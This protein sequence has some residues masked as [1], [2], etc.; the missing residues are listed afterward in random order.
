MRYVA[1][2][3]TLTP[4]SPASE[5]CSATE[6]MSKLKVSGEGAERAAQILRDK[7]FDVD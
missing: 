3:T 6:E 7:G 1:I 4:N 5:A 2:V